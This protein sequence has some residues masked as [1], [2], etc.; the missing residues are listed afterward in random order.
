MELAANTIRAL[1]RLEE[2]FAIFI[3]SLGFISLS[4]LHVT[5]CIF[6]LISVSTMADFNPIF[7]ELGFV[8]GQIFV[9]LSILWLAIRLLEA[10]VS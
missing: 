8:L 5:M 2:G 10:L 3:F 7:A 1:F 9:Y 6:A 4:F